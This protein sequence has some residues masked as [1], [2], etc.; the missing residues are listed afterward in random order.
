MDWQ[1][2]KDML[3]LALLTGVVAYASKQLR[4]LVKSVNV[5]NIQVARLLDHVGDHE[6]RIGVLEQKGKK[7]GKST[8]DSRRSE[9][10][11]GISSSPI[12]IS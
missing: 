1:Q 7:N 10:A 12:E 3:L 9:R 5:L 6:T 4:E 2:A 8:I 11:S